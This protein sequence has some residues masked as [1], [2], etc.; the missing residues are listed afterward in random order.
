MSIVISDSPPYFLNL[1]APTLAAE[2]AML[3]GVKHWRVW[4]KYCDD[5]HYH[6]AGA[7]HRVAHCEGQTRDSGTGYN[8]AASSS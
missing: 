5:W 4:C 8:L 1:D 3:D 7:G 6:G 2:E